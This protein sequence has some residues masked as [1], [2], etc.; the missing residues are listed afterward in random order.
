MHGVCEQASESMAAGN[1]RL[2]IA[3]GLYGIS[4]V[5]LTNC[6]APLSGNGP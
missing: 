6:A 1:G 2:Q 5:E 4:L 3:D